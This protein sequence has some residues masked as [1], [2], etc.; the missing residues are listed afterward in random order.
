MNTKTS[1]KFFAMLFV[2]LTVTVLYSCNK[3]TDQKTPPDIELE[4]GAGLTSADATVAQGDSVFTAVHVVKTEDELNTF[5]VSVFYDGATSSSSL[6]NEIISGSE[7]DGFDRDF[8]FAVRTQAG[9]EKYVYT[10]TDKDG[11]IAQTSIT[12][13]VQ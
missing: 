9:T 12:L 10:V 11:N 1:F 3:N 6:V 5:N 2:A 4:S 13:T 8:N 7:Q